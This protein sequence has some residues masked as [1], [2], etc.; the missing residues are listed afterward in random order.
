MAT[1]PAARTTP[2]PTI[3]R[4][5]QSALYQRALESLPGGTDSN[6]RAWGESTI[7]VDRGKGGMVWDLDGNEFVDLRMGYGPVILGHGDERVDDY[8]NGRMRQGVSFSLTSE[9]EVR[10]MELVKELTGWVDLARMTVSG[11][12][13][14]MHAMR[15]ARAFT[16]REKIVKFEGQYHGVHDYALI[17]VG[18]DDMSELGDADAPVALAWGRGIP[19]A[20]ADTIIPARYNNIAALR[21]IFERHGEEIAAIIVEPVLGNAQAIMPQAGFHKEMRALTEEFGILL[22]F[23]EVKT[24]FR[25]SRGGA[26]EFFGITPDLGTF[27]KAMG[28]GYPAAAFGGRR[29]IMDMLPDKVSHGGTYAGNRVAAAAAVKTL[30]ILRDTNALETIH[31]TGRTI[32][33]GLREILDPV[34]IP[35]HFTGHPSMFGIMFREEVATEYRD[36]ATTDHELYDAIA[37]G[38]HA[39]GAM[40]EPD[41]RE[42]WFI[43]EAHADADIIDRVLTAFSDSLDA[44]LEARAHGV[45]ATPAVGAMSSPGAG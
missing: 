27:A 36:W 13:A 11:T 1:E 16:G 31:A 35:Y 22:I 29:E 15:I 2:T 10:A 45:P 28:N 25:L 37:I 43:C 18:P 30:E 17:S 42:P 39:R 19:G 9:D 24:G 40:P 33:D 7:Y 20:V 26:A 32:Q 38:M 41:S 21:K 3:R 12:E 44:A 8:V 4:D 14:T 23:D 5:A 34:G 6:F